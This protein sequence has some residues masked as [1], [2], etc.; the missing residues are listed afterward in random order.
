M[1]ARL[2]IACALLF[3]TA[4]A[5]PPKTDDRAVVVASK[6]FTESVIVSELAR[7]SLREAGQQVVHRQAL[8][9]TRI[10]FGAL[11]R[12]EID[13]YPDY[14]GTLRFEIYAAAKATDPAALE[15]LLAQNGIAMTKPLGFNN[16]YGLAMRADVAKAK[17]IT[18]ISDL[19]GRTDLRFGLS[20][21]FLDRGDGWPALKAAYGLAQKAD[22]LQHDLSYRGLADGR[23]EVID[24]YTTDAEIAFYDLKV[25]EDDRGFFP[26][27]EAVF[28]Y[29][30]DL[31]QSH[32]QAVAALQSLAGRISAQHMRQMNKRVKI[33][34]RPETAVA[35]DFLSQETGQTVVGEGGAGLLG[36]IWQRSVEHLRLVALSL[37][38]ALVLAVPLAIVAFRKPHLGGAILGFVGILQTVPALALFVFMIPLLGIGAAPTIA[39]LFLY[40]LL[41]IVRNG[42]AG[43]A[44]IP[45]DLQESAQALGLPPMARLWRIELPLALPTLLAGIKTAAV[46]NVGAATLGALIGA[47]GYGQPILTGIRLDDMGLILEGAVPAALLAL[48]VT[49]LFDLVERWL[50]PRGLQL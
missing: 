2:M 30:A 40:S 5:A 35:A 44:G 45:A 7:L 20:N 33:D 27:Y 32:P 6:A 36:R 48:L 17:N 37:T 25:L 49:G 34:R 26:A 13:A 28:L 43:L 24:V 38:M 31:A 14:T 8:G 10:V 47:G 22:G 46:I 50:I 23:L 4:A 12:G 19:V 39:A 3:L 15:R 9:G 18:R 21:E 16:S 1:M 11:K 42:H 29:R 41:P